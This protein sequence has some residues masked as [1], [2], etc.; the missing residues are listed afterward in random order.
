MIGLILN[1]LSRFFVPIKNLLIASRS[2]TRNFAVFVASIALMNVVVRSVLVWSFSTPENINFINRLSTLFV[3]TSCSV[4]FSVFIFYFRSNYPQ[5]LRQ[6]FSNLVDFERLDKN[7][8]RREN[9]VHKLQI[10]FP[11]IIF[12]P[13]FFFY[14]LSIIW[15]VY[16][17]KIFPTWAHTTFGWFILSCA[18]LVLLYLK[19]IQKTILNYAEI[20]NELLYV[21]SRVEKLWWDLKFISWEALQGIFFGENRVRKSNTEYEYYQRKIKTA[22]TYNTF[23]RVLAGALAFSTI[24]GGTLGVEALFFQHPTLPPSSRFI[25]KV[26]EGYYSDDAE[27]IVAAWRLA[28][29]GCDMSTFCYPGTKKLDQIAVSAAYK[30]L[31]A[32]PRAWYE[33]GVYVKSETLLPQGPYKKLSI[34]DGKES[35]F[36]QSATASDVQ[37]K[38]LLSIE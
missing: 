27:V 18:L 12:D 7:K 23:S 8:A 37:N 9:L 24:I 25:W 36:I 2:N 20:P 1:I 29:H 21:P 26:R 16:S 4:T 11:N 14:P 6:V 17:F 30:E 3:V 28:T 35:A 5:F 33:K 32:S 31:E 10:D 15:I 34:V 22:K 38:E 13:W 19:H